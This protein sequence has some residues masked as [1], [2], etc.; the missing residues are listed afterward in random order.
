MFFYIT[1][2]SPF[3]KNLESRSRNIRIIMIGMGFYILFYSCLY[4]KYADNNIFILKYRRLIYFIF[5][6]DIILILLTYYFSKE[7]MNKKRIKHLFPN[8]IYNRPYYQSLNQETANANKI[9]KIN[10]IKNINQLV[11]DKPETKLEIPI[12]QSRN[13]QIYHSNNINNNNHINDIPIY[14]SKKIIL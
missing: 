8:I 12:Y 1:Y 13:I 11:Q 3:W 7:K 2:K 5:V 10:K 14:I 4:S 6:F 9:N